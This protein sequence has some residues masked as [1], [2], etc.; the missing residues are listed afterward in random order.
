MS[1]S[2]GVVQRRHIVFSSPGVSDAPTARCTTPPVNEAS[3]PAGPPEAELE[4][5]APDAVLDV[6]AALCEIEEV[7]PPAPVALLP[8]PSGVEEQAA[9]ASTGATIEERWRIC[10]QYPSSNAV[11]TRDRKHHRRPDDLQGRH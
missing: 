1:R 7:S 10:D 4:G 5:G 8:P 6:A 9:K 3:H 11:A 2:S